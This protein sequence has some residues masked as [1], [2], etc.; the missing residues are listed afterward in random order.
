MTA[1]LGP[2][3][4]KTLDVLGL[5]FTPKATGNETAGAYTIIEAVLAVDPPPHTRK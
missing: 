2:G 4:G 3:E 5:Q 1:V